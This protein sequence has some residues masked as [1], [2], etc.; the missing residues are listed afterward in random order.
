MVPLP[1]NAIRGTRKPEAPVQ[2]S[3]DQVWRRKS[4]IFSNPMMQEHPSQQAKP[5]WKQETTGR[6][7]TQVLNF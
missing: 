1:A 2:K 6:R 4:W 7:P 3:A 5:T